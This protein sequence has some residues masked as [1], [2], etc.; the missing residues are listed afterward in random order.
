MQADWLSC[1]AVFIDKITDF[2]G[3]AVKWLTLLMVVLTF[4]IVTL[5]YGFN[6]G[7]IAM[8]E[9]V[10][11]LHATVIMLGAAYTFKEDGH[12]RVDIFYQ[13]FTDKQKALVNAGGV[14]LLLIPVCLF[15][16]FI[17]LDYVVSS[18]SIMEKSSEA[19]GLPLVFVN[20]TL[21]LLLPITLLMQG[22]SQLC[23]DIQTLSYKNETREMA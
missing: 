4:V 14:L 12:V 1:I 9:S 10:L 13:K 7:Y 16:F 11:Y 23:K 3:H 19:G 15:F 8:Q 20:K 22:L 6:I 17:S 2:L 18:W 5:R 21:L